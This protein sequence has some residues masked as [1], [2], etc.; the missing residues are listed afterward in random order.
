M[1]C[2]KT[3]ILSFSPIFQI[4][5]NWTIF[6]FKIKIITLKNKILTKKMK[7]IFTSTKK[8]CKILC[9]TL[10]TLGILNMKVSEPLATL[11]NSLNLPSRLT[12]HYFERLFRPCKH[13][14]HGFEETICKEVLIRIESVFYAAILLPV[15]V[16]SSI[17]SVI[18]LILS[19]LLKK[20]PIKFEGPKNLESQPQQQ[21][22]KELKVLFLNVCLQGGFLSTVTGNVTSLHEKFDDTYPSRIDALTAFIENQD[23]D[24]ICL[25]EV[26]DL[27]AMK[28]LKKKLKE[29]GYN[30][31][32]E[33]I[34]SHPICV[35]SGLF[36]ASKVEISNPDFIKFT[37]KERSGVHKGALQGCITFDAHLNEKIVKIATTH[38][39]YGFKGSN[40]KSR[41]LQLNKILNT[42]NE[43][44]PFLLG[45]DFNYEYLKDFPTSITLKQKNLKSLVPKDTKT[46]RVLFEKDGNIIK[47]KKREEVIDAAIVKN[48][49]DLPNCE[50]IEPLINGNYVTD[51]Y[52]LLVTVK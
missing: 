25:S 35:N 5:F 20:S 45:G 24:I 49:K 41:E 23:P 40:K 18:P 14:A 10:L 22:K 52:A 38:L 27:L 31:F 26:H 7:K 12:A 15:A 21:A 3:K 33:D 17:L 2:I 36:V 32:I 29:R 30:F 8:K 6:N 9:I 34:P 11:G 46:T 42:T 28:A 47:N 16:F 4:F 48:F 19:N 1:F 13:S 51:H 44:T 43:K 50:V 39:N 37:F